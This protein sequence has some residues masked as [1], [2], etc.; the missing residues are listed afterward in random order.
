MS[1][2]RVLLEYPRIVLG[3]KLFTPLT[4]CR[5]NSLDESPVSIIRRLSD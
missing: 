1:K 2:L 4:P 5:S 3:V